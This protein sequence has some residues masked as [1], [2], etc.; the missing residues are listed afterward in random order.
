MVKTFSSINVRHKY[1][2][3]NM[4]FFLYNWIILIKEMIFYDRN[5]GKM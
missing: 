5:I 4:F 2:V 1:K 3:K